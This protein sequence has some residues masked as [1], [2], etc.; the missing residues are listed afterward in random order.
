MTTFESPGRPPLLDQPPSPDATTR[1]DVEIRPDRGRV[2]V[3]PGG[4]LDMASVDRLGAA[5]D[6][7][8]DVGF[9]TVVLDLRRLAFMDSAGL[10]LIVAESRRPELD[11]RLIDGPEAVARVFD[12]CGVRDRLAFMDARELRLRG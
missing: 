6:G 7:L 9:E 1:F 2:I 5:I 11:L 8:V 10:C 12:V 4:E 3:I